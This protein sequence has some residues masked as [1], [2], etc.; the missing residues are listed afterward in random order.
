MYW[1]V[2]DSFNKPS[3]I[4]KGGMDGSSPST[5]VN[6]EHVRNPVSLVIDFHSSRLYWADLFAKKI[7]SS[8]LD[9]ADITT[10]FE[11]SSEPMGL[12][13]V[14]QK[15]FWSLLESNILQSGNMDGSDIRTVYNGTGAINH[16]AIPDWAYPRNRRNPCEGHIC[17]GICVLTPTSHKC[18]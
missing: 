17:P 11:L 9:G 1:S 18:L 8:D 3:E 16:L 12:A 6:K 2:W 13:I 5:V 10:V 15:L 14:N 4:F 7:Q